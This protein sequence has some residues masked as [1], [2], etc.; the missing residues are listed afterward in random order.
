M[1]AIIGLIV[2][3]VVGGWTF[4]GLG[5]LV[6]GIAGFIVG[7]AL[8]RKK[9]TAQSTA[10]EFVPGLPPRP[11]YGQAPAPAAAIAVPLAERMA[12]LEQRVL[13]LERALRGETSMSDVASAVPAAA[14]APAIDAGGF[15]VPPLQ[16][17][18]TR[19]SPHVAAAVPAAAAI[20]DAVPALVSDA[21]GAATIPPPP[22][23]ESAAPNPIWAWITGGNTLARVGVLLLFIGVGFLLKYAAEH[24]DVPLEMRLSGVAV[25]AI[26]MLI[27]GW[28]LRTRRFAYA[29]V[30]QGGGIGI[31][32]L[33]VFAALRLYALIA[34]TAAFVL[35]LWIAALSAFL[36]VR[37]DSLALAILGVTGGFLAPILTSTGGG[38]HVLLFSYYAVLNAGIFAIAWFKAW[39]VLNLLGFAFTFLIGTFWGVTRYRPEQFA[40]TEPFLVLFFL[41][42]VGIA[43]LYALRSSLAVRSYVDGALVFGTPL[44]AA[45]L[46]SGLVRDIPYG[47]AYSALAMSVVYVGAAKL[48]YARRADEMRQLVE[49]FV[50]LGLIFAT[51]A[52][53]LALDA[54]WTTATWALEGAAMVWVG[55]RQLRPALR[56]FGLLLQL[57]AGVAFAS[58]LSVWVPGAP[59]AAI[60]V[61][62]SA[63]VGALLVAFAG[64]ASAW[65]LQRARAELSASDQ[66]LAWAA[67]A[68]GNL[69]WL[70]AGWREIERFVPYD[71]R[72]PAV[73]AF[74]ALTAAAFTLA[75][76]RLAWP[77]A[78][79]PALASLPALLLLA[80]ATLARNATGDSHAFA[81]GGVIAWPL[82]VAVMVFMLKRFDDAS[83]A[84]AGTIAAP[85]DVWHGGLM[86]LV[87]ILTAH[88][89]T[90]LTW[91]AVGDTGVWTLIP[92][93]LIPAL[94]L[95]AVA[96]YA[97]GAHWPLGVHARGYLVYG[98]WVVAGYLAL[99]SLLLNVVSDGDPSPLPYVP[100]LNPIDLTLAAAAFALLAWSRRIE[101]AGAVRNALA[102][103]FALLAFVWI[104]AIVLRTIHFYVGIAYDP[105]VLWRSTLVQASLS[106]LWSVM[107]LATMVVAARHGQRVP[108][109]VGA[110][111]LA[112]V[113]V[114]L[115]VIELSHVGGIPR[116]VSF[117]GVGLLVLLIGYLAPVPPRRVEQT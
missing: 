109:V 59:P 82:A 49:A 98:G 57:G 39:R 28:R 111:L 47:M 44:V 22:A 70:V 23:Y 45:G 66:S 51:L 90:W 40:T 93:V 102:A 6:G 80:L 31:L 10:S 94:G 30:V 9:S 67:F 88:E 103:V 14:I 26:A 35:L 92:G 8:G 104:N 107:A 1:L 27:V 42:Y 68:W 54:R 29:M 48:L 78:R 106:L 83:N 75:E 12:A 50:A 33:T 96:R 4:D 32:Y 113:V 62:N 105:H 37:Q 24:V 13:V 56:G 72:L 89:L 100:I 43:I 21:G 17:D 79:I 11:N 18:G 108:W 87:L 97:Q 61:L 116:I 110:V 86:L 81:H 7:A 74:L 16:P 36:A 65:L 20:R 5:A 77:A 76:R 58:G 112:V 95:G 55:T 41:F 115:F 69:W 99:I 38:D 114:K 71:M 19:A 34:P 73:V 101:S 15:D 53:P 52:V 46:Q 2:G 91:R 25:G 85:L 64:L 84:P 60:P 117:I 63:C 3:L